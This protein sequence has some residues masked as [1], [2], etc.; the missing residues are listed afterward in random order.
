MLTFGF[1][2]SIITK[3]SFLVFQKEICEALRHSWY[4]LN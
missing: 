4:R 3:K 2:I 1:K